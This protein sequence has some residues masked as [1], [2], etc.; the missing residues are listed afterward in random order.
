MIFQYYLY[1]QTLCI[2]LKKDLLGQPEESAILQLAELYISIGINRCILDLEEVQS[3]TSKGLSLIIRVMTKLEGKGG[4][5]VLVNPS[6]RVMKLLSI[7]KLDMLFQIAADRFE[8]YQI[9]N[10][11]I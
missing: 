3:V 5:I 8:A 10:Q 11:P 1:N 6:P 4:G 2:S 7:T 9:V